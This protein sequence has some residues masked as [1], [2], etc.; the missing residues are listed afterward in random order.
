[1]AVGEETTSA[2]GRERARHPP[3]WKVTSFC[4]LFFLDMSKL[5]KPVLNLNN[6]YFD[7]L[8]VNFLVN[9][10]ELGVSWWRT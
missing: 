5:Q 7:I 6:G 9:V 8:M 3:Y 1:M 2:G 4:Q 10:S